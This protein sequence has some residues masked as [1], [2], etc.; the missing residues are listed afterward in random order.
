MTQEELVG[1][2]RLSPQQERLWSVGRGGSGYCAQCALELEGP[3]DAPMLVAA[4]EDVVARHEILRTT[5]SSLPGLALPLQEVTGLG[6]VWD[7]PC[8]LSGL[9]ASRQDAEID[10]RLAQLRGRAEAATL[11]AALVK[12]A[13]ERHALLLDLPSLCLDSG[14]IDL[15]AAEIGRAYEARAAAPADATELEDPLQYADVSDWLNE[16][17]EAEDTEVGRDYWRA[18]DV[19]SA[20]AAQL[21]VERVPAAGQDFVPR[22]YAFELPRAALSALEAASHDGGGLEASLLA[23]WQVSLAR[24][25]GQPETVAAVR[26]D[27]RRY[28]ELADALGLF[29][30]YLPVRGRVAEAAGFSELVRQLEESAGEARKWQESFK[31][32]LLGGADAAGGPVPFLPFAFEF[33]RAGARVHAAGLSLNVRRRSVYSEQFKL[34]LTLEA[35]ADSV[36]A[37]LHYDGGHFEAADVERLAA[38]FCRLAE[39]AAANFEA[40]P[41]VLEMLGEDERR[42][43]LCEFNSTAAPYANDKC[44]HQLFEEQAARTPDATAVV[45]ESESLTYRELNGRAN[46]LARHLLSLGVG[47]DELVGVCVERSAE[48]VVALLAVLKAGAAYVPLDP[49]YPRDRLA[50]MLDDSRPQVLLTQEGLSHALPQREGMRTLLLDRDWDDISRESDEPAGVSVSNDSLAYCIY[51]SGSTGRPKGVLI[52]HRGICNRLLWM[53]TAYPLTADDRLLQKTPYSFDAS[54]WEIFVPLM[55]GATLV[56]ARPGGHQD[57]AYL[58]R[59]AAEQRITVLQL[60][61]SML[62]VVLGERGLGELRSLRRVYCGG[63]VLPASLQESF[64]A[65][66][67][68]ELHNLYGPTEVSIDAAHWACVRGDGRRVVPIGRP[69]SN[70]RVY[71]LDSLMRPVPVGA[72]GELYVG[73][74]GLARGYLNRPE[75]TAERFVPHPFSEEPGARLYRTGDLARH[76]PGGEIEYLGRIDQQVKIRGFRIELGEIEAALRRHYSVRDAVVLAREDAP[77]EKRLIAY[78]VLHPDLR[79]VAP[80]D[81]AETSDGPSIAELRGHIAE[82]LPEYMLPSAF[83]LLDSLPTLPNGKVNRHALLALKVKQPERGESVAPRTPIEEVLCAVWSELLG[84]ERVGVEDNFFELGGH[85]LL[86]TQVVSRV[87]QVFEVELP[88]RSLFESPT[89]ASLAATVEQAMRESAGRAPSTPPLTAV[90]RG[91]R[92]PLSFAQQRLWFLDRLEPGSAAYNIPAAVR[93]TG[94]LDTAA[95]RRALSA[96][97]SRHETLRTTFA[98][99]DGEPAQLIREAAEVALSVVDLTHLPGPEREAAALGAARAEAALPFDLSRGPLLR[100]QLL[101]LSEEE[102][103]L[104]LTMHHIVSDGWSMGILVQ[105]LSRAYAAFASG[106]E[107]ALPG[108]PIQYADYAAWQRGWMDGEA[109]DAQLAYWRGQLKGAPPVLELPT[110]RPRPAVQTFAGASHRFRLGRELTQAL[111]RLGRQEGATLFMTL[112]AAF[113]ALLYRYTSQEDISVGTPVAGRTRAETEA[114]IGFFVNTLVLRSRLHPEMS[115]RE[116]LAEVRRTA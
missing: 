108:L 18:Q 40:P 39:S 69:L 3:L 15:L 112:L 24:H 59:V 64:H 53:Q 66:L 86:V 101:R 37:A 41:A 78:V 113:D 94:A 109:L 49:S 19:A 16:L 88:L 76:L 30:K 63:E 80:G 83:L 114:L 7:E 6:P 4:L 27:G 110:D 93:L 33:T 87:R 35:R 71:L 44:L 92:T 46:Q 97:V 74:D 67:D 51:T 42:L 115:F 47:P 98:E 75:L 90:P 28:E 11:R 31:W 29:E 65:S 73:G 48:M 38:Q 95:L 102:H 36:A 103:V 100:A 25:T 85:S 32:E 52:S 1:R 96:V 107:P 99:M 10:A 22:S 54:V 111:H 105:E 61:P 81:N 45:Y 70:M 43:V 21:G 34:R 58:V 77:G 50:F 57:S 8:D 5:F 116:L 55:S 106:T 17:L 23:C 104:L 79:A 84:V 13:P 9:E 26:F 91:E 60:V 14:G 56:M 12:F 68:S 2:F 89:V 82:R 72:P 62:Q 20:L